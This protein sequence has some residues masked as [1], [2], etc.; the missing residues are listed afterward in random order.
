M[1]KKETKEKRILKKE[2]NMLLLSFFHI[3]SFMPC[4]KEKLRDIICD[5]APS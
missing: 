1:P 5:P 4:R 2:K 3:T